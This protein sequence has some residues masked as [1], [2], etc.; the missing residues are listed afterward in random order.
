MN[1][2]SNDSDQAKIDILTSFTKGA[3]LESRWKDG[4]NRGFNNWIRCAV[5]VWDFTEIEYRIKPEPQTIFVNMYGPSMNSVHSTQE[6]AHKSFCPS[7]SNRSRSRKAVQFREV[8][9]DE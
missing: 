4:T 3:I 1:R 6:A 2:T 7:A 5:P 9:E 8:M